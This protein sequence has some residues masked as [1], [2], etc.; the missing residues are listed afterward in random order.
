MSSCRTARRSGGRGIVFGADDVQDLIGE[1][2]I[3][4]HAF[5]LDSGFAEGIMN[6]CSGGCLSN[7]ISAIP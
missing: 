5:R 6:A 1:A 7:M 2:D 4:S 3:F